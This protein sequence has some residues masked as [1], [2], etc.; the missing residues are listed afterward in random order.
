M[1]EE[2]YYEGCDVKCVEEIT[3][4]EFYEACPWERK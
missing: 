3:A 2:K 4:E 1:D